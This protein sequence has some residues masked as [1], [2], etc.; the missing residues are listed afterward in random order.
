VTT[1]SGDTHSMP[2]YADLRRHLNRAVRLHFTDG[3]V[4]DA[5][6]LGVDPAE[7]E[8]LTYELVRRLTSGTSGAVESLP[9]TTLVTPLVDLAGWEPTA[10]DFGAST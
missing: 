5:V 3:E 7:H 8:D 6:L 1:Q 10:T 2:D 4:V 9:G